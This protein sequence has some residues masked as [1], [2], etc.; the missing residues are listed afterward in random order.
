MIAVA[1]YPPFG[2]TTTKVT[3]ANNVVTPGVVQS[4]G[5]PIP[6]WVR[7]NATAQVTGNTVSD[8]VC[9]GP[10]CGA[11][12][13]SEFQAAGILVES[14]VPGSTVAD[15]NVSGADIGVYE[16]FSPDCCKIEREQ[17][18]G[19]PLFRDRDPGRQ[20]RDTG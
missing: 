1:P 7:L 2:A 3:F 9:T 10:G 8:G 12:P 14:S 11:D 6:I 15:N 17:A 16:I 19:Q 18:Q 5:S 20:R 4:P 13:I